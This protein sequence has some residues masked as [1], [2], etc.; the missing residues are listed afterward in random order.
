MAT[1][2]VELDELKNNCEGNGPS[3]PLLVQCKSMDESCLVRLS[4]L[5]SRVLCPNTI[6]SDD[7]LLI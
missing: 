2:Q 4:I 1:L 6:T 7:L 5:I 3:F